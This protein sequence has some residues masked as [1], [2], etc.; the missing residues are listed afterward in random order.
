MKICL[1]TCAKQNER[2]RAVIKLDER[3]PEHVLAPS[4]LTCDFHVAHY[5]D[6]Y[7]LTLDVSGVLAI[8]CQ[9]CLQV[10]Q[11]DYSNQ[12]VLAVCATDA[13]AEPL[14]EHYECMV[15]DDEEVDLV[16]VLTD[17]LYLFSPA[18]HAFVVDCDDEISQWIGEQNEILPTTLGL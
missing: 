11:H 3:L 14:M 16:D 4:E 7:L 9:R 13:I 12:T 5:D 8:T 15:V 2:Q 10:F 6:Y 1:K 18:K 17:E